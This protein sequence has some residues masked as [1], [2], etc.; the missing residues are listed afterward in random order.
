MRI[1]TEVCDPC[2]GSN[3][4]SDQNIPEPP[5]FRL[6][7]GPVNGLKDHKDTGKKKRDQEDEINDIPGHPIDEP[8]DSV[9]KQ[10]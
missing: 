7:V 8:L 9:V 10:G 3:H 1:W 6:G 4:K 5:L 2:Q